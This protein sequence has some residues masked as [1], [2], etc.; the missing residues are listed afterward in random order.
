MITSPKICF[1]MTIQ[2]QKQYLYS[3]STRLEISPQQSEA[4]LEMS[5]QQSASHLQFVKYEGLIFKY[6]NM[7]T[8]NRIKNYLRAKCK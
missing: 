2:S 4:H 5:P 3:K 6:I 7:I 8:K 1:E